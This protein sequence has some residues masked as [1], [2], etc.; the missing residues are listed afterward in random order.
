MSVR[1]GG[2][3]GALLLLA[4]R[5]ARVLRE[6]LLHELLLRLAHQRDHTLVHRVLVLLEPV[7]NVV[8]YLRTHNQSTL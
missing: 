6:Q 2:E 1:D 4:G 7:G 5:V 8:W 3:R